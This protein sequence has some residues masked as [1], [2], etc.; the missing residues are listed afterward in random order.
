MARLTSGYGVVFA[1]T[2]TSVASTLKVDRHAPRLEERQ[3][4]LT[5]R[6][7]FHRED[8]RLFHRAH[9]ITSTLT[10]QRPVC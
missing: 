7:A 5:V 9:D 10:L 8:Q 1:L 2:T 6:V 3:R 4:G